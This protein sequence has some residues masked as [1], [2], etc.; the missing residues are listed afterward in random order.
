MITALE[1]NYYSLSFEPEEIFVMIGFRKELTKMKMQDDSIYLPYIQDR[2][3]QRN[4]SY[5]RQGHCHLI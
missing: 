4:Y 1:A 5:Y 3:T 2:H